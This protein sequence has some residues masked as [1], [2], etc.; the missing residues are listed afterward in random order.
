MP[1]MAMEPALECA[2]IALAEGAVTAIGRATVD[3]D[4]VEIYRIDDLVNVYSAVDCSLTAT[5]E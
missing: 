4:R 3:G 2:T 1:T 5:F